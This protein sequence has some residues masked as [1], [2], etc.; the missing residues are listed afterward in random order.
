MAVAVLAA[1]VT[2]GGAQAALP[3]D[4]LATSWTYGAAGLPA[5]WDVTTGSPAVVVAVVDSG[6]DAL[7]PDLAGAVD[8]GFD[9]VDGDGEATDHQGHGT[10]VAYDPRVR[11]DRRDADGLHR[12]LVRCSA[13][14]LLPVVAL[15]NRCLRASR[16]GRADEDVQTPP[17][18]QWSSASCRPQRD[19]R[20]R[21]GSSDERSDTPHPLS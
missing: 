1:A 11:G 7:H 21:H 5:A 16:H 12:R 2:T 3:S 10:A 9:F 19:G 15:S 4:P 17:C 8:P 20:A 13:D 18:R 14:D 6:V